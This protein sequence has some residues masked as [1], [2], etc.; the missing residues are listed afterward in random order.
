MGRDEIELDEVLYEFSRVGNLLRVC[1]IDPRTNTEI[2][3]VGAPG[4]SSETLK[5]LAR[6]KLAYVIAKKRGGK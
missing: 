1:A 4:Y 2:T 5:R 6:Q 3:M